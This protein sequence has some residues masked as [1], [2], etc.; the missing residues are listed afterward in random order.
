MIVG[1]WYFGRKTMSTSLRWTSADL[2]VMPEDGK[3]RAIIDGELY[4]STQPTLVHQRVCSDTLLVLQNWSDSTGL[5]L[6]FFA[7]GVI[8]ADDDDVAPDVVWMSHERLAEAVDA[9]GHLRIPPELVVEVLSPGAKNER[10]DL[11]ATL[12]LQSRRGTGDSRTP[13]VRA[14]N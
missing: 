14:Q 10:R 9:A 8:F 3:R 4:V 11:E 6:A 5:G 2:E 13:V 7:P 1:G 12:N